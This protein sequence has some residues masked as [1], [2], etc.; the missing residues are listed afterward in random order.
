MNTL[1]LT[2]DELVPTRVTMTSSQSEPLSLVRHGI[3]PALKFKIKY[4]DDW[5][6][7]LGEINGGGHEHA[8]LDR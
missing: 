2:D 5:K 8:G 6:V 3:Q 7:A 4:P 1:G